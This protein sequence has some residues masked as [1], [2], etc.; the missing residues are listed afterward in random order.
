MSAAEE[1][2]TAVITGRCYCG[3]TTF[4]AHQ[5]PCTVTYCHCG[6]CRRVTGAPVAAFAAFDEGGVRFVP[7]EGHSI[8][9]TDG[10]VRT[11]C[12]ACGSPL[13][14]RNAYLADTVYIAVGLIDQ[15]A[16]FPPSLHSHAENCLPWL[17]ISDEIPRESGSARDA[18]RK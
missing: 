12:R 16:E 11:F 9:I 18:L 17:H 8:S 1:S 13:T 15:A 6:D 7:D 5:Q 2:T 3:H 10:V 4:S 14:G